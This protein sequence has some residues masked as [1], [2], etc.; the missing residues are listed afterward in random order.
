MRNGSA[1]CCIGRM[2][3]YE[4][5]DGKRKGYTAWKEAFEFQ[6]DDPALDGVGLDGRHGLDVHALKWI[7][8]LLDFWQAILLL[9]NPTSFEF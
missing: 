9:M 4:L 1:L 8:T 5:H 3:E 7:L 6:F 2:T